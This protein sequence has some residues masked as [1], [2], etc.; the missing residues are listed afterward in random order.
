MPRITRW[1]MRSTRPEWASASSAADDNPVQL[2]V[3][4]ARSHQAV[5][6]WAVLDSRA[7]AQVADTMAVDMD[8]DGVRVM[9]V[10]RLGHQQSNHLVLDAAP[11]STA[12]D[13][14]E[15]ILIVGLTDDLE[16]LVPPS[17]DFSIAA[18]NYRELQTTRPRRPDHGGG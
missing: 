2:D 3:P 13:P 17:T 18:S 14:P 8:A 6:P 10:V 16:I 12:A 1:P 4:A 7:P 11:W 5:Q 15:R 9:G